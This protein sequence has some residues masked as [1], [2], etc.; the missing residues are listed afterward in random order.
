LSNAEILQELLFHVVFLLP[1]PAEWK[2]YTITC[3][4]ERGTH[5]A[6]GLGHGSTGFL[7]SMA[8]P[9]SA[10]EG[11]ELRAGMAALASSQQLGMPGPL[12]G[13]WQGSGRVGCG[14][15]WSWQEGTAITFSLSSLLD[16]S[17]EAHQ[18]RCHFAALGQFLLYLSETAQ[19]PHRP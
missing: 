17:R 9:S 11:Q 4:N 8:V 16:A 7:L 12:W 2:H 10:A 15:A 13:R 6:G 5:A 1:P 19:H 18:P 14:L 3:I